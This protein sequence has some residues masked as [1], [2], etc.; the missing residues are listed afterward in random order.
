MYVGGPK[1]TQ[2]HV[3]NNLQHCIKI[4]QIFVLVTIKWQQNYMFSNFSL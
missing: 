3:Y 2:K 4:Y 1:I